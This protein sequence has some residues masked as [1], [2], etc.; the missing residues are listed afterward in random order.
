MT[1]PFLKF[2]ADA[3]AAR[4]YVFRRGAKL[5][6][7]T[8]PFLTPGQVCDD[9]DLLRRGRQILH[10]TLSLPEGLRADDARWIKIVEL[11]LEELGVI[12]DRTAWI[13]GRHEDS[14]C[15][16]VHVAVSLSDFSG[17]NLVVQKKR[18]VLD[19]IHQKI[20]RMIGLEV[21]A[22]F[23]PQVLT[24]DPITPKRNLTSPDTRNL[25]AAL[26]QIFLRVQPGDIEILAA[27]MAGPEF[28]Y[29]HEVRENRHGSRSHFWISKT[30]VEI[31]SSNLG[32]AW[33]PRFVLKRLKLARGLRDLR[34]RLD[35]S[36]ALR[37]ARHP[38]NHILERLDDLKKRYGHMGMA[39]AL[40]GVARSV[41][42][43]G[44]AHHQTVPA[45]GPAEPTRGGGAGSGRA[46]DG[47]VGSTSKSAG[48]GG[49][50]ADESRGTPQPDIGAEI[51]RN[52]KRDRHAF[53]RAKQNVEGAVGYFGTDP[54]LTLGDI[55]RQALGVCRELGLRP[56]V[57]HAAPGETALDVLWADGSVTR[58]FGREVKI[59]RPGEQASAFERAYRNDHLEVDAQERSDAH[60]ENQI[61]TACDGLADHEVSVEPD[62][63]TSDPDDDFAGPGW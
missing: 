22:Y 42:E 17:H 6:G 63:T 60:V 3:T 58:V 2:H 28:G 19:R 5:V 55:L 57:W 48:G 35:L 52:S 8:L 39:R 7:G 13:A 54:Q 34:A 61:E 23:S 1:R 10:M 56:K 45:S 24:L 41:D 25:H 12:P 53:D 62:E 32:L 36:R 30:G 9:L 26:Q 44:F 37:A 38:L 51:G 33:E 20:N 14:N 27:H 40:K 29:R 11:T 50:A 21:P 59:V 15:D 47:R 49:S 4:D 43:H 46:A 18:H 31:N 16:H